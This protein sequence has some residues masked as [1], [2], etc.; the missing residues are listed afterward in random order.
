MTQTTAKA[1]RSRMTDAERKLWRKL[2]LLR[3]QGLHF[4]KQA[5]IG[6]FIAD[7]ACH[8]ARLVI[9]VD[10]GQH[11][12]P[13]IANYD[14]ARTAWLVSQG[15]AVLRFWNH[16]VLTNIGSVVDYIFE[17][18]DERRAL[19]FSSVPPP[20]SPPRSGGGEEPAPQTIALV[21]AS[22]TGSTQ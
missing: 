1:L 22:Q 19:K 4:R 8:H 5:S 10:G 18:A 12:R 14:A 13:D 11:S 9:E 6:R 3:A 16:D 7:F 17:R 21:M 2:K 15:Y 20:L